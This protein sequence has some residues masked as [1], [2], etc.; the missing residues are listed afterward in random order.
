MQASRIDHLVVA[1]HNLE[2]GI[3]WC[4]DT[5][6]VAALP[7][8]PHPLMGTHNALLK[9]ASAEFPRSYLEILAID[10]KAARPRRRA[11]HRWFDLDD[12][13]L[14]AE[15]SRAGPRLIHVVA[16]VADAE[17]AVQALG[18]LRLDRGAVI[19]ASRDS[20][21][22]R[23][24][25]RITVREDGQRLFYGTLP[26]LIQWGPVHPVDGMVDAGVALRTLEATHP[27]AGDLGAALQAIG[28]DSLPV[29]TGAPNLRA[30]FDSPRGPV[31][32]ESRGV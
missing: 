20:P 15:L 19:A 23:L 22:G 16:E 21:A 5:F 8:G 24:E 9:I 18:H 31:T 1:A 13:V 32:L 14:Q 6:G 26:T 10:P 30:V 7:G 25:W 28:L 2:E 3:A 29:A 4:A 17:A 11:Q 27:R 12:I